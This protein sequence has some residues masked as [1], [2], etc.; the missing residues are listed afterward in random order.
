MKSGLL[1]FAVVSISALGSAFA[2]DTEKSDAHCGICDFKK[3][4]K[5][6]LPWLEWGAEL[7]LRAIWDKNVRSCDDSAEGNERFWQRYRGRLWTTST[8]A[9]NLK[10]NFG[11]AWEMRN[12]CRPEGMRDTDFDEVVFETLNIEW[13]KALGLPLRVKVGRQNLGDLNR[14]LFA[15]GTP[16]DGSRTWYFDAARFTYE[17]AERK[18]TVDVVYINQYSDSDK[19]LPPINDH[20]D[21]HLL[22]NDERA[23]VLYV[24]NKSLDKTQIDGYYIWRRTW[25]ELDNGWDSDLSTIGGRIAGDIDD[26]WKYYAE[27]ATQV[28]SKDGFHVSAMGGN[29]RISYHLNDELN[30][31]FRLGYEYRSAGRHPRENFDILWGRWTYISNIYVD[32]LG[33]LENNFEMFS[34]LHRVNFGWSCE[35]TKKLSVHADYNLLFA[36]DNQ[37]DDLGERFSQ[38]G[39]LRGHLFAGLLK[40]KFNEHVSG[41]LIGELLLPGDYYT[42]MSNDPAIFLRYELM[43]RF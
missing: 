6:A 27:L 10:L 22:E 18:T 15:E 43:F 16:L 12:Y 20:I 31:N 34:N 26:H 36:D 37:S 41:H 21:R 17:L 19:W 11:A 42:D 40:Y 29:S 3:Q 13:S 32:Y 30:N 39:C 2:G 33:S 5:E 7:R 14:W 23:V 8:L 4:A 25:R 38:S 35:P 1:V 9:D 24:K 28:G